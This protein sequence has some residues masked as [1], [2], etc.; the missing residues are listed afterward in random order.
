MYG[1]GGSE[2]IQTFFL[3]LLI[4]AVSN[5]LFSASLDHSLVVFLFIFDIRILSLNRELIEIGPGGV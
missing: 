5:T 4:F 1:S 2:S 3:F